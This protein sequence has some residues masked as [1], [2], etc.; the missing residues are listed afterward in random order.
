MKHW[1]IGLICLGLVMGQSPSRSA[2]AAPAAV[3]TSTA[4][5]DWTA[6]TWSGCV[7]GLQSNDRVVIA[8]GHVVVLDASVTISSLT[9]D[10]TLM[11]GDDNTART[12]TVTG[13]VTISAS[14]GIDISK[15]KAGHILNVGG[16]LTN[17]GAFNGYQNRNRYLNLVFIGAGQQIISGSSIATMND[18]IVDSGTRVIFPASNLPDVNGVMTV[19]PGGAVQQTQNVNNGTTRFMQISGDKYRGVDL[20]TTNNLGATT[21]VIKTVAGNGCTGSTGSP[22]YAA[23]C[24]EVTPEHDLPATVRLYA[25]TDTQ[26]NGVPQASLRLHRYT[27][28]GWQQL[29]TNASTGSASG[30]YSYAQADTPGFSDFLLGGPT[31]PTAVTLAALTAQAQPTSPL[32]PFGVALLLGALVIFIRRRTP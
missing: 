13:D 4:S 8:A 24:Y 11:F 2:Y 15:N 31:D 14:G 19:Q 21:V 12:L 10:G 7:G 9:L 27:A 30:G 1:I 26:L 22:A 16:N 3:C 28:G 25:L 23:R 5:G 18:L 32:L 29:T 17:D 6:I 20:T